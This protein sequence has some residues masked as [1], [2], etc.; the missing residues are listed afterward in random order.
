MENEI[1]KN[2]R[3]EKSEETR[4]APVVSGKV[5]L[6][7][8]S[9]GQKFIETFFKGDLSQVGSG[10]WFDVIVPRIRDILL[11]AWEG[12]G[13]GLI[14]G[15]FDRDDRKGGDRNSIPARQ[16]D[17]TR[18]SKRPD[19]RIYDY[20]DMEDVYNYGEITM[21]T[22][23]DAEAT[24]DRMY[25]LLDNYK[26]VSVAQ[27][28]ELSGLPSKYTDRNYGWRDLHDAYITSTRNGYLIK[29]PRPRPFE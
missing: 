19:R 8:K 16:V 11:A 3:E 20:R 9:E 4:L 14:M 23:R 10:I 18:Y 21:E 26:W 12:A 15:N 5:T 17:F 29:L 22:R 7:K 2:P 25:E 27:L 28:Y 24:L 1:P 13:R 6:K